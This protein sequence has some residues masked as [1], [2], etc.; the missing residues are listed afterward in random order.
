MSLRVCCV[1]VVW[2]ALCGSSLS[3]QD[4]LPTLVKSEVGVG[5]VYRVGSWTPVTF[6]LKTDTALTAK[7]WLETV[8]GDDA[9]VRWSLG[10]HDLLAG[11]TTT[12]SSVIQIG[13]TASA[14]TIIGQA[15]TGTE[16]RLPI[17][18]ESIRAVPSTRELYLE[19]GPSVDLEH[20]CNLA[21]QA[22]GAKPEVVRLASASDLPS[23]SAALSMFR[24]IVWNVNLGETSVTSQQ[25]QAV[26]EYVHH[27]GQLLLLLF[28]GTTEQ[29][30]DTKLW[31]TLIPA[32]LTNQ[33]HT[34]KQYS[35]WQ[36]HI[37]SDQPLQITE[38]LQREPTVV[39]VFEVPVT[40]VQLA[41]DRT[42]VLFKQR[43]GLGFITVCLANLNRAPFLNWLGNSRDQLLKKILPWSVEP[44]NDSNTNWTQQT[45]R[46]GYDD[47]AGQFR[48]AL[49]Q[50]PQQQ[51]LSFW[52]MM[53]LGV[54]WGLC[55]YPLQARWLNEQLAVTWRWFLLL[56][57]IAGF[58]W[59]ATYLTS[60]GS[61][62]ATQ[63]VQIQAMELLDYSPASGEQAGHS[64]A[65][66]ASNQEQQFKVQALLPS[67]HD[68]V[69]NLSWFGLPGSGWG[70]L[71]TKLAAPAFQ[72]AAYELQAKDLIAKDLIQ[73]RGVTKTWQL[74][75]Q[76]QQSVGELTPLY[77]RPGLS[78]PYGKIE[79]RGKQ[80]I[81]DAFVIFGDFAGELGDVQPGVQIDLAQYHTRAISLRNAIT[82]QRFKTG[83]SDASYDRSHTD[84]K[85]CLKLLAFFHGTGGS[86]YAGLW[87][88]YLS[89]LDQSDELTSERVCI[90]G[91]TTGQ[92]T[93]QV[94]TSEQ[95]IKSVTVDT[96]QL[97]RIW[98]PVV[99]EDKVPTG[100]F[101]TTTVI[102]LK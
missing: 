88:R 56:L 55:W 100:G 60:T 53:A 77:R 18:T 92:A 36:K 50:F 24:G 97:L 87:N 83:R 94:E 65:A 102:E 1:I 3:A 8:D 79:F 27:G 42:P 38:T 91:W 59:L 41:E 22:D 46:L 74:T 89:P 67:Q 14:I 32:K 93:W 19:V 73:A 40:D 21:K 78:L 49:S 13:R 70:G 61:A 90:M 62:V 9:P 31:Q 5:G 7:L 11:Q 98:L 45:I 6:Q 95:T 57:G 10:Q 17:S 34:L 72:G 16:Y 86:R 37:N 48:M 63:P 2:L 75:W 99:A 4:A 15:R 47:L 58:S 80:I 23:D 43:R 68:Q 76:Q 64:W 85:L 44:L 51:R 54:L 101:T 25:M 71:D 66:I 82:G 33:T 28:H 26:A 52:W 20:L 81:R 29:S 30:V 39:P 96:P 12:L 69:A 84:A 35:L